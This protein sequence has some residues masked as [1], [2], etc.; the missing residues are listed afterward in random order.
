MQ[1]KLTELERATVRNMRERLEAWHDRASLWEAEQAQAWY[2]TAHGIAEALAERY[3]CTVMQSAA[4]LAVLSPSVTWEQN[5][6]DAFAVCKAWRDGTYDAVVGTY[7]AQ[8]GKAYAILDNARDVA[9]AEGMLPFIGKRAPKTKAFFQN[10][11]Y[12]HLE[13]PVTIDR[14]ILRAL[15]LPVNR[16]T[17]KLYALGR[18]AVW[19]FAKAHG[20][21][22]QNAQ[23]LIWVVIRK[24][25][26]ELETTRVL[27]G[28]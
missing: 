28:F 27:P 23:A 13:G 19:Q 20:L 11:L 7:G 12:P 6:D 10:I 24:R 26:G 8:L 1:T 21:L 25:G 9:F 16:T 5:V 14:W 18:L 15:G 2:P 17:P 3:G 4:V 22:P